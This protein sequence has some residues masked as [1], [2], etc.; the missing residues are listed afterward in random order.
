[1]QSPVLVVDDK[2]VLVGFTSDIQK[3][4][5]LISKGETMSGVENKPKCNC[6]GKC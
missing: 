1:M 5:D 2:P 4:K 6:G 3:I